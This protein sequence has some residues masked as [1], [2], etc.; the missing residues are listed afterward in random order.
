[1]LGLGW[2]FFW[3]DLKLKLDGLVGL[4]NRSLVSVVAER[5]YSFRS[6]QLATGM[7]DAR[8]TEV[9]VINLLFQRTIS[10]KHPNVVG[11]SWDFF[12]RAHNPIARL[13]DR[14]QLTREGQ[15]VQIYQKPGGLS[16]A[17]PI[18]KFR[19]VHHTEEGA[20]F[21]VF[22]C[23]FFDVFF[24][25]TFLLYDHIYGVFVRTSKGF[26]K[27]S[28]KNLKGEHFFSLK[29]HNSQKDSRAYKGPGPRPLSVNDN[30]MLDACTT[31]TR[32]FDTQDDS[33][34]D[35]GT[36]IVFGAPTYLGLFCHF[37]WTDGTKCEAN[38]WS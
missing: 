16:E 18:R 10:I 4:E 17:T 24:K 38:D 31:A 3:V 32:A 13:N 1:M 36:L 25:P 26:S 20:G 23:F 37:I 14:W 6:P 2:F 12:C 35:A 5:K 11:S 22:G 19:H 29:R 9:V 28:N 33:N 15:K 27:P 21:L 34:G 30:A 7:N 8:T